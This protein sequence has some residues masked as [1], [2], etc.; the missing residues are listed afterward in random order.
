M[1]SDFVIRSQTADNLKNI[2]TT[3][4]FL[5]HSAS[6]A[7]SK[8]DAV[9]TARPFDVTVDRCQRKTNRYLCVFACLACCLCVVKLDGKRSR[10]S[11]WTVNEAFPFSLD[12]RGQGS[13][14]K[15]KLDSKRSVSFGD[16]GPAAPWSRLGGCC[17]APAHLPLFPPS[18]LGCTC[19][20]CG[21][22]WPGLT[23]TSGCLTHRA[24]EPG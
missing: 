8:V 13:R 17:F 18:G 21:H 5:I 6:G 16:Q 12:Q 20:L 3:Y 24:V 7:A 15:V 4:K 19:A 22:G 1:H 2:V 14:C 11:S 23:L 9:G 10:Q